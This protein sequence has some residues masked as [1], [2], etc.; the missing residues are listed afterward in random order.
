[1]GKRLLIAVLLV[2]VASLFGAVWNIYRKND[3]AARLRAQTEA[4]LADLRERQAHL[5]EDYEKLKT[6]R[7]LEA[8][9]REQ[10]AV[11]AAGEEL[12]VIVEPE[13]PE[14]VQATSSVLQWFKDILPHW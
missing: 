6:E 9:L 3:E 10:Y 7:G 14:P 1:M 11:G 5:E 4:Q 2:V 12:I 8:A 13:K